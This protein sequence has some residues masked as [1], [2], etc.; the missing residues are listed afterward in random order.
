MR[1]SGAQSFDD[2]IE[3][4]KTKIDPNQVIGVS[5]ICFAKIHN[6]LNRPLLRS[7]AGRMSRTLVKS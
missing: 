3:W 6:K 2:I 4:G 5:A 7:K 1:T